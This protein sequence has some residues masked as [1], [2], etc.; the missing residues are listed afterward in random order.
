[1]YTLAAA[2]AIVGGLGW[3]EDAAGKGMWLALLGGLIAGAGAALTGLLD[4]LHI[5][6]DEPVRRTATTHMLVNVS[7][8][9]VF[10]VAAVLQYDGFHDGRVVTSALVLTMVAYALLAV[11]GWL[12]GSM[13]FVHGMRV[14]ESP[15][16]ERPHLPESVGGI[17]REG[18]DGRARA[19][20]PGRRTRA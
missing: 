3:I 20:E 12:G 11:G 16:A 8:T 17:D 14:L 7:A 13:V 10:V 15:G 4:W 2:L 6:R 5:P 9:V 19:D 18:G 1:M